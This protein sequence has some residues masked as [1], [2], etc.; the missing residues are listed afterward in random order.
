MN[1]DSD[2][3]TSNQF[4]KPIGD[5]LIKYDSNQRIICSLL[6]KVL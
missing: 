6:S 1:N 2:S 4:G 5:N 3:N